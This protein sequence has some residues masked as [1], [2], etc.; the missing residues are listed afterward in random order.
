MKFC[1]ECGVKL[2]SQKFCHECGCNIGSLITAT[3]SDSAYAAPQAADA[4]NSCV[5]LAAVPSHQAGT[6]TE[7]TDNF[8]ENAKIQKGRLVSYFGTETEITLP[9][10]ISA[11]KDG[12]FAECVNLSKIN[13]DEEN[14]YFTSIDGVLFSKDGKT[15]VLYP[16]A[17]SDE[18]FTF[19]TE[20]EKIANYAFAN[21]TVKTV[22]FNDGLRE[23]GDHAFAQCGA[24]E[25]ISIPDSVLT[26]S[27]SAFW[28]CKNI[29]SVQFGNS[30]TVLGDN[31]FTLCEKLKEVTVPDSVEKFGTGVFMYC[32][33]L[34]RATLPK[35]TK[36][37]KM[38]GTFYACYSLKEFFIP[39]NI[40]EIGAGTFYACRSISEITL[41]AAVRTISGKI[42]FSECPSLKK[43][44]LNEGLLEIAEETFVSSFSLSE[45]TIPTSVKTI[46]RDAFFAIPKLTVRIPRG[47]SYE[48]VPR[49][50]QQGITVVEY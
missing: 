21:A 30:L 50:W 10:E 32:S 38:E 48:G 43:I 28:D 17:K 22:T 15:L 49:R 20:T 34:E 11:I 45:V 46:G 13:V 2:I 8:K 16:R 5:N 42:A 31:S 36:Y 47:R 7:S 9:R 41:P 23:I 26:I 27:A 1:P 40:S 25:R 18:H 19:P 39:E 6:T 44:N 29:E 12:A 33:S 4:P 3:A 37:D 35:R 14:A 24:L